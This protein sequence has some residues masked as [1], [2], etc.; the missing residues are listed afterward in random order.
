M[1]RIHA[2]WM[3][4]VSS[5]KSMLTRKVSPIENF[6]PT[7]LMVQSRCIAS[8][9]IEEDEEMTNYPAAEVKLSLALCIF[10][11]GWFRESRHK[12]H[13]PKRHAKR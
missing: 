12:A 6:A 2:D 5:R 8:E 10:F 1:E 7:N 11:L 4:A 3:R 9:G 13:Q